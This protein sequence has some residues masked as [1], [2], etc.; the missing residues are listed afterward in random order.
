[1]EVRG[2]GSEGCAMTARVVGV[3]MKKRRRRLMSMSQ[4]FGDG[5]VVE[6]SKGGSFGELTYSTWWCKG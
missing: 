3:I 4:D 5:S 1:M 2:A 6:A